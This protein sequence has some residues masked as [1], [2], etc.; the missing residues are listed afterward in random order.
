MTGDTGSPT[1][2]AGVEDGAPITGDLDATD[3]DGLTD[4]TYFTTGNG[5]N[6]SATI[7]AVSGAWVYTPDP[8]FSGADTFT[9]TVTDDLGNTT[10]QVI[11]VI[12][13]P[14]DDPAVVSGD[15]SGTSTDGE[16]ASG[17]LDAT[18]VDGLTNGTVFSVTGGPANGTAAID[19]VSGAWS[20]TPEDDFSG[21]DSFT[22]TITDDDGF[23]AIQII[24]LTV[25]AGEGPGADDPTNPLNS[26]FDI[27]SSQTFEEV[28]NSLDLD[29]FDVFGDEEGGE[30]TLV[31]L[32]SS[33]RDGAIDPFDFPVLQSSGVP[34]YT[35]LT[36]LAFDEIVNGIERLTELLSDGGRP[37]SVIFL[38]LDL[39]DLDPD[40]LRLFLEGL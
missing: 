1:P 38:D 9:V 19:P 7:D 35:D 25:D 5:A 23:T 32:F 4:G 15:T 14:V 31:V 2:I 18:D 17:D 12:V 30:G 37:S 33:E 26:T 34:N 8:N 40:D 27:F 24:S 10:D 6:G 39:F 29:L 3:P 16:P 36:L 11:S 20:Y 13:D 28:F 21:T 22:V